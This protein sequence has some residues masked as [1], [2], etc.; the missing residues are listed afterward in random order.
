[1]YLSNIPLV[2]SADNQILIRYFGKLFE[3]FVNLDSEIVINSLKSI[4][5]HNLIERLLYNEA[6]EQLVAFSLFYTPVYSMGFAPK[7]YSKTQ[8]IKKLIEKIMD[9]DENLYEIMKIRFKNDEPFDISAASEKLYKYFLKN[10]FE[11]SNHF[12]AFSLILG[13]PESWFLNELESRFDYSASFIPKLYFENVDE[14]ARL[15]L[16]STCTRIMNEIMIGKNNDDKIIYSLFYNI[17]FGDRMDYQQFLDES[18]QIVFKHYRLNL[19]YVLVAALSSQNQHLVPAIY[20][21]NKF[22][23]ERLQDTYIRQVFY[24]NFIPS[25]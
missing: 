25:A 2:A 1:M 23:S 10:Y 21:D 11:F 3:E 4:Q 5:F 9:V 12:H 15:R 24:P 6:Y 18:N 14:E 7:I 20:N 22:I 8:Q 16:L 17:R 19:S 13:V